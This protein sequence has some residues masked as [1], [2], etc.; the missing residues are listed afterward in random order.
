L[1]LERRRA[2]LLVTAAAA[3]GDGSTR[4]TD[5]G[6]AVAGGRRSKHHTWHVGATTD[7]DGWQLWVAGGTGRCMM[8]RLRVTQAGE[9]LVACAPEVVRH[10]SST[11]EANVH[12]KRA[13]APWSCSGG[14]WSWPSCSSSCFVRPPLPR[15]GPFPP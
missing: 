11:G 8:V 14:S 12:R 3:T 6:A 13:V 7:G 15:R 9:L 10:T 2:M 4:A 5:S 1:T